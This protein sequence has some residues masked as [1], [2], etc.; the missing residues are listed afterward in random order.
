[1]P[2]E[3]RRHRARITTV[4]ADG[5]AGQDTI[6][7]IRLARGGTNRRPSLLI[8]ASLEAEKRALR[9]LVVDCSAERAGTNARRLIHCALQREAAGCVGE[10]SGSAG[11]AVD[12]VFAHEPWCG[13]LT[14]D[15]A[16]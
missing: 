2:G 7:S 10:A 14:N 16:A 5:G 11:D 3:V 12:L 8:D 4:G 15:E 13:A 6:G 9:R 1:M